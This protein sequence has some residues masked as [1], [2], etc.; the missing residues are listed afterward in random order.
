MLRHQSAKDKNQNVKLDEN[1]MCGLDL[2]TR[3]GKLFRV[4]EEEEEEEELTYTIAFPSFYYV[5]NYIV[6]F[7]DI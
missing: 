1:G 2:V 7:K 5:Y 3:K 6:A 4:E